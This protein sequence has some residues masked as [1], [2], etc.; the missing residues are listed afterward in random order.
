MAKKLPSNQLAAHLHPFSW[1]IWLALLKRFLP[2]LKKAQDI[3]PQDPK[4]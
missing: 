3:S 1:E 4:K 2:A